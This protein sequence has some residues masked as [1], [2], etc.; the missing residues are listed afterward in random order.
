MAPHNR[1]IWVCK[2]AALAS[3]CANAVQAQDT[4]QTMPDDVRQALL[5]GNPKAAVA[6]LQKADAAGNSNATFELGKLYRLGSGLPK[7]RAR[8]EVLLKKAADHGHAGATKLLEQFAGRRSEQASNPSAIGDDSQPSD[9]NWFAWIGAGRPPPATTAV[10]NPNQKND[11]GTPLVLYAVEQ[12]DQAWVERFIEQQVDLTAVDARGNSVLHGA[13]RHKDGALLTLLL[14]SGAPTDLKNAEGGT[15]LHLATALANKA[16]IRS[17][18]GAGANTNLANNSG[19]TAPMIAERADDAGLLALFGRKSATPHRSSA[20]TAIATEESLLHL[21]RL[22]NA[23]EVKRLLRRGI[24]AN[25]KDAGG[26]SALI[27]AVRGNHIATV[28]ILLA[29]GADANQAAARNITPLHIASQQKSKTI[30]SLLL[31]AGAS[32]DSRDQNKQT[33]LHKLVRSGCLECLTLLLDAGANLNAAD[34]NGVSPI[35]QAAKTGQT[36]LID[37]LLQAGANRQASDNASRSA[38]WWAV[39]NEHKPAALA[40]LHQQLVDNALNQPDL[41][42]LTPLHL[43]V[44]HNDLELVTRL[45]SPNTINATTERG[46]TPLTLAAHAGETSVAALLIELGANVDQA[47]NVGDTPLMEAIHQQAEPT[48]MLLVKSGASLNIHNVSGQSAKSLIEAI[49][50]PQWTA[51]LNEADGALAAI[52]KRLSQ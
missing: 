33:P 37:T 38:L 29:G 22:G 2:I 49:D 23:A 18:L 30:T 45:A 32:P 6:W 43:A 52:F 21:V 12:G 41:D 34:K 19:W 7:D 35:L 44:Q 26:D 14:A 48:A 31:K 39:K 46:S 1:V 8:A 24:S 16:A 27:L 28:R 3:L 25:A 40:L 9:I 20:A 10:A 15:P 50:Q 11:G 5:L 51:M 47:N 4:A 17:L 36:A 13:I 42:G